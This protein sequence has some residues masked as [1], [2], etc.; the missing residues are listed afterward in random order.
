MRFVPGI[1][2]TSV[3]FASSQASATWPGRDAVRV[4]DRAHDLDR[5]Q[6]GVERVA[7]SAAGCGAGRFSARS[8]TEVIEPVRKPRPSGLNATMPMPSS[9]HVGTISSSM[10]RLHS[11]HSLC[12]A[13]IGCTAAARRIV[14]T[15]ASDRPRCRTLPADDQLGHRADGLLDGHVRCRGGVGSR[16]RCSRRRAGS[17]TPRPTY[18][19]YSGVPVDH[20]RLALSGPRDDAEL[21]RDRDLV[22]APCD[23]PC[24]RRA[25]WCAVRR[26]RPC[27]AVS[28]PRSTARR[29]TSVTGRRPR[30]RRRSGLKLMQPRPIAPTDTPSAPR[31]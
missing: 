7:R 10:S 11:D 1:G 13:A 20:G 9:R 21:G 6:V 27:R 22:A 18:R 14:S 28:T 4:G 16:G 19:T 30:S 29:I 8:S 31:V 3:P 24:R 2:T 26:H 23:R 5:G 17:T 25:R 15:E 12:S